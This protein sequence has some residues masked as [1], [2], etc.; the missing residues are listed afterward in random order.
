[1][2]QSLSARKSACRAL[3]H[4]KRT[5]VGDFAYGQTLLTFLQDEDLELRNTATAL[6]IREYSPDRMIQSTLATELV[7][8]RL[9]D[10]AQLEDAQ[11]LLQAVLSELGKL[12]FK[13]KGKRRV[14]ILVIKKQVS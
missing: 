2:L 4:L 12:F 6:A 8:A 9:I 7:W 14:N 10:V 3:S 11:N 5:V 13:P 1:M